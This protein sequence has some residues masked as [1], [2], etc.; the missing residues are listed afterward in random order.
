MHL[1]NIN[2]STPPTPLQLTEVP[3]VL[4]P[5]TNDPGLRVKRFLT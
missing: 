4:H 1:T 5:T 2:V 3:S